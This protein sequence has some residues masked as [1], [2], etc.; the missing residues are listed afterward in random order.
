MVKGNIVVDF[1]VSKRGSSGKT[2]VSMVKTDVAL[3]YG[4]RVWGIDMNDMNPDY[5]TIYRYL[6]EILDKLYGHDEDFRK[7]FWIEK[8][9]FVDSEWPFSKEEFWN[10]EC[11]GYTYSYLDRD[12]SSTLEREFYLFNGQRYIR[13]GTTYTVKQSLVDLAQY[14]RIIL[15]TISTM[16]DESKDTYIV[17]DTN[18]PYTSLIVYSAKHI[19]SVAEGFPLTMYIPGAKDTFSDILTSLYESI[20]SLGKYMKLVITYIL[21]LEVF[22]KEEAIETEFDALRRISSDLESTLGKAVLEF[23]LIANMYVPLRYDIISRMMRLSTDIIEK[24]EKL[25]GK[26][27]AN[28]EFLSIDEMNKILRGLTEIDVEGIVTKVKAQKSEFVENRIKIF[29]RIL[30]LY[31]ALLNSRVKNLSVMPIYDADISYLVELLRT[32]GLAEIIA[33]NTVF[34]G[35]YN[36]FLRNLWDFGPLIALLTLL[37][38]RVMDAI[39]I[40]NMQSPGMMFTKF[41]FNIADFVR[42]MAKR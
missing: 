21:P 23:H 34:I 18:I 14:L 42:A 27:A 39:D 24:A 38:L 32:P 2:L 13:R 31:Y 5:S 35:D 26:I 20:M 40:R 30:I 17:T 41:I 11:S 10:I 8:L 19:K 3:A 33:N 1:I 15:N 12:L 6:F 16:G 25:S 29:A 22:L 28:K 37:G 7:I 4:Y 36:R 9:G